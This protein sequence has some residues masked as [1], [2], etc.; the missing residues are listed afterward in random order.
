MAKY[1]VRVGLSCAFVQEQAEAGADPLNTLKRNIPAQYEPELEFY[2]YTFCIITMKTYS[3]HICK[4]VIIDT[5]S[6]IYPDRPD[7][8]NVLTAVC[9]ETDTSNLMY[10]ILTGYYGAESYQELITELTASI[11]LLKERGALKAFRMQ[12]YLFAV[13]SGC[14]F[15]T[16][17]SS[18]GD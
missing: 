18:F 5:W 3:S 6:K 13:D 11:P 9:D 16:L 7:V 14:G 8:I 10:S 17:L 1:Y 2:R 12:N 15:T 4:D